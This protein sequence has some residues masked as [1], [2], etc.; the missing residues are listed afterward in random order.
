MPL[1]TVNLD[2]GA[3]PP[4]SAAAAKPEASPAAAADTGKPAFR[5]RYI[6]PA[7]AAVVG[8][9]LLWLGGDW[10]L[11]GRFEIKTDNAFI[12]SD[13]TRVTPKV[14]GYVTAIHVQDNQAVKKG[15]LLITLEASDFQTRVA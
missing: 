9:G 13:I 10:L 4:D 15:D 12:R 5:K 7:I 2:A 6:F 8:V 11:N 14:Q 3:P 1:K